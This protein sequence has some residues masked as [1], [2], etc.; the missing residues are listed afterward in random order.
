[1]ARVTRSKM[2]LALYL[3]YIARA[4]SD[5]S[6]LTPLATSLFDESS[7]RPDN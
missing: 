2:W 4:R 5:S 1:M 3:M 7:C 6:N